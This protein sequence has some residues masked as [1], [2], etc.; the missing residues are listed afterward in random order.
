MRLRKNA[1]AV[2]LRSATAAALLAAA[3]GARAAD[4]TPQTLPA[5]D[6][7][8]QAGPGWVHVP[9]SRL[10]HD[11]A[12]SASKEDGKVILKAVAEDAASAYV[13][14]ASIDPTRLPVLEWRWRTDALIDAADNRDPKR[15]DAPVRLIVGFD[16]DKSTLPEEEQ[17]RFDRAKK[18]S[19]KDLPYATLMYIWENRAPVGT[20]IPSA[21]S[22][23][24]KMIV[25]ESGPKGVGAWRSYRRNLVQDYQRAFGGT[26]QGIVGVAVMTDTDNTNA[27]AEGFYGEINFSCAAPATR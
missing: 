23:R 15:E 19:G 13:H 20:V 14:M 27:K 7:A 16:G 9:L 8:T 5:F 3:G 10:K 1:C 21:H 17:R 12:Y 18:I 22:T 24:V 26:P 2:V 6:A 25:V 4:C 11:T